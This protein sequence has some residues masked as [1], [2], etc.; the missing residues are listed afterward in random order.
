MGPREEDNSLLLLGAVTLICGL[1]AFVPL[2]DPTSRIAETAPER[3][4]SKTVIQAGTLSPARV[5]VPFT[6][7]T[8]P[9]QR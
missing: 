2:L 7:N 9:A 4:S 6:P 1:I 5:I 3:I 8:T